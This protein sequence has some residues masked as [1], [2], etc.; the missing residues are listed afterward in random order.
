MVRPLQYL[1]PTDGMEHW[2]QE[3]RNRYIWLLQAG[4]EKVYLLKRRW[5]GDPCPNIDPVR[6]THRDVDKCPICYGTTFVGGYYPAIQIVASLISPA[7][8]KARQFD[9]GIRREFEPRSWTLWKPIL[10]NK[11][12][13]VRKDGRRYWVQNTTPTRWRG[14]YLR[15]NFDLADV[16]PDHVIYDIPSA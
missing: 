7:P 5:L 9:Y 15:Q 4:G 13:I 16:E 8:E 6:H 3:I 1:P 14:I 11:D 10:R 12:V 2:M